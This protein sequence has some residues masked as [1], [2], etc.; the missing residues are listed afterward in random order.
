MNLPQYN[1]WGF[2]KNE[3][4]EHL[5]TKKQLAGLKLSPKQPVAYID[6]PKYTLYLYDPS[7]PDSVKPKRQATPK[8]LAALQKLREK[9][10]K[11]REYRDWWRC[12]GFIERD[13]ANVVQWVQKFLETDDWVILDCETTGLGDAEIVEIAI[14]GYQKETL[15][16]TFVKPSIP[17]PNDAIAVHGITDQMIANA[18]TFTDIHPQIVEILD[19]KRILIYNAEADRN[20]LNYCCKLYKLPK[21]KFKDRTFCLMTWYAQWCGDYSSYWG[22]YRWQPLGGG[23]KALGDCLTA[24]DRLM[25][26]AKDDP[27]FN[28][29]EEFKD[30]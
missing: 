25:E 2:G 12:G 27:N 21:I 6:T 7:N 18:P 19:G 10:Q 16:N 24:F 23:H 9:Q 13:R 20:F 29:P 3:P 11:R 8:Q 17:I 4:P 5:K 14:I 30:L 1:W 26:I 28:L 15:L 22:D